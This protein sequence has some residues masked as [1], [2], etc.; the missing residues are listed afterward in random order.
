MRSAWAYIR[1]NPTANNYGYPNSVSPTLYFLNFNSTDLETVERRATPWIPLKFTL[2]IY[3]IYLDSLP[4]FSRTVF[5]R[6]VS[7][8]FKPWNRLRIAYGSRF[9]ILKAVTKRCRYSPHQR[10][11]KSFCVLKPL[12]GEL[13]H[14]I[15]SFER[16]WKQMSNMY[17]LAEEYKTIMLMIRQAS[18]F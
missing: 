8:Y 13:H 1:K 9:L 6:A 12:L 2:F 14:L 4:F 10:M 16:V 11:L 7:C 18:G 5:L 15:V 3:F 17:M